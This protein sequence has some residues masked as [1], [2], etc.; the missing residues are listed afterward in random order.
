[1]AIAISFNM[2]NPVNFLLQETK[3]SALLFSEMMYFFVYEKVSI[4][5]SR[6]TTLLIK[7]TTFGKAI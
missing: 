5:A 1:M 7:I 2:L 4:F 3:N 6:N